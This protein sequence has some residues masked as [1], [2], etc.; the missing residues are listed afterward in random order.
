MPAKYTKYNTDTDKRNKLGALF[1]GSPFRNTDSEGTKAT[2]VEIA[3][4]YLRASKTNGIATGDLGMF[5]NNVDLKYQGRG[6]AYG[7][8]GDT[9]DEKD[10]KKP[11]APLNAFVPDI[12]APGP[13]AGASTTSVDGGKPTVRTE[14]ID[15]EPLSADERAD[16]ISSLNKNS[17]DSANTKRP[18]STDAYEKTRLGS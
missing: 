11:G 1:K 2:V 4:V 9:L 3:Q 17:I 10:L 12:T 8:P 5:P 14:G 15:K 18:A 16:V 7:P 13:A 6:L